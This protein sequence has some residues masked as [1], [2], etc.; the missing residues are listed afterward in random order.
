[1]T[2]I[3]SR[4]LDPQGQPSGPWVR[5]GQSCNT[6]AAAVA[7]ANPRPVLTLGAIQSAFRRIAFA[8]PTVHVQPEGDV[9]LVNLP[10][11][12]EV[13]WLPAGFEPAEV[14]S[15]RLLG[16]GVRIRPLSRSVVYQFGDGARLGPTDDLGGPYPD[17][18]VRHTYARSAV[19][20]VAVTATYGGEFSVDGGAWQEVGETVDVPGPSVPVR[21]KTARNQ[22]E[23]G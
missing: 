9:T 3:W 5:V 8:K 20:Q 2:W 4:P 13:R 16:R 21:V 23:A 1:M 17:G 11:F 7:A 22:L 18:R 12:Y 6:P 15:V 10:T 14:A 19:A